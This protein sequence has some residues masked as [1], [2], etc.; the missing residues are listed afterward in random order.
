MIE[1][2]PNLRWWLL[3]L[4][5]FVIVIA[6]GMWLRSQSAFGIVDHQ[7]AGNA[8]T[9]DRIQANW[10][11]NGVRWLAILSMAGDL[12]FIGIYS[13]GA[14]VAGRSF[15]A[16]DNPLLRTLGWI[17]ALAVAV[18]AFTDYTETILQ[19]IQ[20]VRE[21]GVGW[22]AQTVASMQTI[23]VVSFLATFLGILAALAL[24]RFTTPAA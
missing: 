13:L 18:F 9:V 8:D 24:H 6:L 1:S 7:I 20:L 17:V 3:G 23:K 16:Q 10:R 2:N 19:F 22:M 4:A 21:Q 14:W 12:V 5:I 11:A 15:V